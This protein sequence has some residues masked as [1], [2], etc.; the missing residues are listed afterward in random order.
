MEITSAFDVQLNQQNLQFYVR[1]FASF[2]RSCIINN[3]KNNLLAYSYRIIQ[4]NTNEDHY[5]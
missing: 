4:I 2:R 5:I 1:R 3:H